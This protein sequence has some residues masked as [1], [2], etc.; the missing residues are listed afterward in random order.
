MRRS[1]N[2]YGFNCFVLLFNSQNIFGLF[3][4]SFKHV[5]L[6]IPILFLV[7]LS[8]GCL[9]NLPLIN[10]NLTVIKA[11]WLWNS[12][13]LSSILTSMAIFIAS[14]L[15]FSQ[16]LPFCKTYLLLTII[17][18]TFFIVGNIREFNFSYYRELIFCEVY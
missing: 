8:Q 12:L 3:A 16:L 15:M 10:Y 13:I 9:E 14:L 1:Q 7:G 2:L 4:C 6:N 17:L 18:S 11:C 5:L